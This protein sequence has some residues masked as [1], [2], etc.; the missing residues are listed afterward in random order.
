MQSLISLIKHTKVSYH[1]RLLFPVDFRAYSTK[2]VYLEVPQKSGTASTSKSTIHVG[3]F[4]FDQNLH[5]SIFLNRVRYLKTL[6]GDVWNSSSFLQV[7]LTTKTKD[8]C[9]RQPFSFFYIGYF[10]GK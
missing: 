4:S 2:M 9:P 5:F 1:L 3:S 7:H 10:F 8:A 6:F